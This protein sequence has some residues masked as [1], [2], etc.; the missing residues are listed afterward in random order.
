LAANHL[1]LGNVHHC[2][3]SS[4]GCFSLKILQVRNE[5]GP[6]YNLREPQDYNLLFLLKQERTGKESAA[7]KYDHWSR[8][9]R[10]I[11]RKEDTGY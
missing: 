2:T 11:P 4:G 6:S 8:G 9:Q 5:S 3:F 7:R 1:I 10:K